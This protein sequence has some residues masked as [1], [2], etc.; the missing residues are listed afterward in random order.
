MYSDNKIKVGLYPF[1][2]QSGIGFHEHKREG[3][4]FCRFVLSGA[5][6]ATPFPKR[7][8]ASGD[9]GIIQTTMRG[10]IRGAEERIRGETRYLPVTG[11]KE[12]VFIMCLGPACGT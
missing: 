2:L 9:W 1:S 11:N 8:S 5:L 6:C 4:N 3:S 12:G 7:K 10:S